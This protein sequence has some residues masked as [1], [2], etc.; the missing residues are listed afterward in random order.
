MAAIEIGSEITTVTLQNTSAVTKTQEPITF[1]HVFQVGHLPTY[2]VAVELR[3]PAGV[4]VPC[5]IDVKNTYPDGSVKHAI[6]SSLIP[7]T[8]SARDLYSLRRAAIGPVAAAPKPADFAGLSASVVLTD[9]GVDVSG[10]ITGTSYVADAAAK[11]ASGQYETWLSGAIVSEWIV[12]LPLMSTNGVENPDLHARVW[13][14]AYAGINRARIDYSIEN[15]WAKPKAAPVRGGSPWENVNITEKVYRFS[16]KAG[17]TT[18]LTRSV[19]G[20]QVTKLSY[21]RQGT[22]DGNAT[23]LP[24]DATVYTATIIV[25]GVAKITSVIGSAAQNYGQLRA[26]LNAQMGGVA[27]VDMDGSR[28]GLLFKS[29]TK[30]AASSVVISYGTLF[31][32]LGHVQLYRPMF[33]DEVSHGSS[34]RWKKTFW[35][36]ATSTIHVEHNIEYLK[37]TG[38][39][40]NYDPTL[41]GD[42]ATIAA[43]LAVMLA[44]ED[45]NCNGITKAYFGDV[46]F[47]PGIGILPE[48]TAMY[49]VNQSPSAKYVMLKQADLAGGWAVNLRDFKTDLPISFTDWPYVTSSPNVGDSLNWS[50]GLFEKLPVPTSAGTIPGGF[51]QPDTAHCPDFFTIPYLLSGDHFYLEGQLFYQRYTSWSGNSHSDY[52]NGGKCLWW[53]DQVRSQ[54]WSMRTALHTHY[55]LPDNHPLKADVANILEQNR[56]WYTANYLVENAPERNELGALVHMGATIYAGNIGVGQFQ[57]DF[58]TSVVGR[59]LELGYEEWRPYFDFKTKF[60]VG[61]LTSG[62]DFC[63]QLGGSN[64]WLNVRS[65]PSGP[66]HPT[67]KQVYTGTFS[68]TITSAQCGSQAM[69]TAMASLEGSRPVLNSMAGYPDIIGGYP[70]NMQPAVAYAASFNA[71]GGEDSWL[72]FN[73]RSVKPNYNLG[74]QFA[75]VPREPKVVAPLEPPPVVQPPVVVTPVPTTPPIVKPPTVLEPRSVIITNTVL[76]NLTGLSVILTKTTKTFLHMNLSASATGELRIKDSRFVKG[77]KYK[78]VV[79]NAAGTTLATETPIQVV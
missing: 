46:G 9:T 11:L 22:Y 30:G 39:I 16:L 56:L 27:T 65:V 41:V 5:Q 19:V 59:A 51:N 42:N 26:A 66:I 57:D 62:P 29:A 31:P 71:A 25:D 75:I 18:V 2:N 8:G 49:L 15:N 70:S 36:G 1:G 76:A 32:A 38:A 3:S 35:W 7:I 69:T 47:A 45:I 79:I 61:R 68:P 74:P 64:M 55:I 78:C 28:Q 48:W 50:T 6:I 14:R 54:A 43:K 17:D 53:R 12:R 4:S 37:A 58:K 34:T 63:W 20:T 60:P 23:G 77:D 52:R 10:P 40:P 72:V 21:N 73:S 24:N 44:N 33:G 13:I 67:F